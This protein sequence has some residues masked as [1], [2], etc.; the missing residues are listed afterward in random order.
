MVPPW[1]TDP[2][3]D[4]R[5]GC[6]L[7]E[8]GGDASNAKELEHAGSRDRWRTDLVYDRRARRGARRAP[9]SL[10]GHEP[11]D[12]GSAAAAARRQVPP[13]SLRCTRAWEVH[14]AAGRFHDRAAGPRCA[15]GARRR[16][17]AD[18]RGLRRLDRRA[19]E[20][21][22]RP[23][24]CGSREP[25]RAREYRRAHRHERVVERTHSRR[26]RERDRGGG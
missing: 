23:G 20:R 16:A 14:R 6:I 18:G 11:R 5:R 4:S 1:F 2:S 3:R 17:R 26:S 9:P 13:H 19:D 10:A 12:V 8:P 15:R 21:V 7:I 22:A 24:A 25:A